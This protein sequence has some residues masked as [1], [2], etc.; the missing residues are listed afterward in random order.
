MPTLAD[1][2]LQVLLAPSALAQGVLL[3]SKLLLV[4]SPDPNVNRHAVVAAADMWECFLA[5]SAS[6]RDEEVL[7]DELHNLSF[8][9][10][11]PSSP[12][13]ANFPW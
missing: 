5:D 11:T 3:P 13:D 4:P 8:P 6:A 7:P 2:P 12:A 1:F 10:T 9:W